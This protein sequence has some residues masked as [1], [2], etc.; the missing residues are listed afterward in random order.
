MKLSPSAGMTWLSVYL[1]DATSAI[2]TAI[3]TPLWTIYVGPSF[4]KYVNN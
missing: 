3:D 2:N 1:S 4:L